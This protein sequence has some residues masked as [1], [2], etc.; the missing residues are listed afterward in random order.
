MVVEE[1]ESKL[2]VGLDDSNHAGTSKGDILVAT[3][4][5]FGKDSEEI[6][7]GNHRDYQALEKWL[8]N[9][10]QVVDYRFGIILNPD[11]RKF[12][13]LLPFVAPYLINSFLSSYG[14]NIQ[15]LEVNI[16]GLANSSHKNYLKSYF[17]DK[18]ERVIIANFIKTHNVHH[19]PKVVYMADI[20]ASNLY[21]TDFSEVT[22]HNKRVDF[23]EEELNCAIKGV[24]RN[25]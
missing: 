3:F 6:R 23:P 25:G 21:H 10:L 20:L 8:T 4:S 18:F 1:L 13:P 7:F 24:K 16:D 11:L 15:I 22:K 5:T 17:K 12:Q 9:D 2:I 14:G 19:C